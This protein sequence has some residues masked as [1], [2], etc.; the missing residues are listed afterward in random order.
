MVNKNEL[1]GLL[2]KYGFTEEQI[3]RIVKSKTLIKIGLGYLTFCLLL[4]I[5]AILLVITLCLA[6]KVSI[7]DTDE[8]KPLNMVLPP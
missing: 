8:Y 2:Q 3:N 1:V 4:F 7:D 6:C 5:F